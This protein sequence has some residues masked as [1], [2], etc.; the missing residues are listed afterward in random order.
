MKSISKPPQENASQKKRWSKFK[1]VVKRDGKALAFTALSGTILIGTGWGALKLDSDFFD[2]RYVTAEHPTS[3]GI[4]EAAHH[5]QRMAYWDDCRK[6]LEEVKR[7]LA[8]AAGTTVS[9][10]V[11]S[12]AIR[13]SNE[14]NPEI[15]EQQDKKQATKSLS[16]KINDLSTTARAEDPNVQESDRKLNLFNTQQILFRLSS[17]AIGG[18]LI[19]GLWQLGKGIEESARKPTSD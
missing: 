14:I 11:R 7:N 1:D 6:D 19:F 5:T 10:S 15:C 12:K 8:A 9:D 18:L 2:A 16:S 4:G 3:R 13:I 17:F